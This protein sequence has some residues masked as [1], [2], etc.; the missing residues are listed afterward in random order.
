[1]KYIFLFL[2]YLASFS[3]SYADTTSFVMDQ[4]K[5]YVIPAGVDTTTKTAKFSLHYQL[6]PGWKIYWRNPGDAG[7]PTEISLEGSDNLS[8]PYLFWPTPQRN[9][10]HISEDLSLTSYIYKDEVSLPFHASVKDVSAPIQAKIGLNFSI[11]KNICIPYRTV[12]Y[13]TVPYTT[14]LE[15][16]ALY[17]TSMAKVPP[18]VPPEQTDKSLLYIESARF[19]NNKSQLFLHIK[20]HQKEHPFNPFVSDIFV[21]NLP[22]YTTTPPKILLS[23]QKHTADFYIPLT[24]ATPLPPKHHILRNTSIIF[25][26]KS[27]HSSIETHIP[28]LA[29]IN[30]NFSMDDTLTSNTQFSLWLIL[31]YAMIGGLI[32]NIMPCVLPVLSLKLLGLLNQNHGHAQKART[33]LLTTASGIIFSFLALA[34][35]T[36]GLKL[37]GKTVGWGIHFQQPAFIISL[38]VII[39]LFALNLLGR[40]EIILPSWLGGKLASHPAAQSS[41]LAGN[42][43]TGAFATILATPCSAPFLGV[44]VSF[45]LSQSIS[46]IFLIFLFMGIGMALPY[47]FLAL[48]PRLISFLPKP[49]AWMVAVKHF[50]AFLLL[51]TAFW[52]LW[53]LA[54]QIGGFAATIVGLLCLLIKFFIEIKAG[55]LSRARSKSITTLILIALT[56]IIPLTF[57]YHMEQHKEQVD[58]IWQPF[59]E[60]K[61]STHIA[62]NRIVIVDATAEWCATCKINKFFVLNRQDIMDILARPDVIAMRLDLTTPNPIGNQFLEKYERYGI[63]FNIVYGPEA[64][65]GI[66]L[67]TILR[68]SKVKTAFYRAGLK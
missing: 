55:F 51:G 53:V 50:L 11:C 9:T 4:G 22:F 47:L 45:A 41:G 38:I 68:G 16:L 7:T 2:I 36:S 24:S 37:A 67:P 43:L 57:T 54:E 65:N 20:A 48:F 25:T 42:F 39:I 17:D 12:F 62:E 29:I 49:G 44:A 21:E 58:A 28:Q 30:S 32:L 46:A 18:V 8:S 56:F 5:V 19:L 60:S 31:L 15:N 10:E 61:I 6:A 52:L 33:S 64:P 27:G 1:M 59:E 26:L 3:A 13:L 14:S 63:P 66:I 23:N 35:L 34:T 40:F